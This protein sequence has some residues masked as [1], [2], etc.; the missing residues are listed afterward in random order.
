MANDLKLEYLR[1]AYDLAFAALAREVRNWIAFPAGEAGNG[2]AEQRVR[3]AEDL[4]RERRDALAAYLVR[5]EVERRAYRLWEQSGRP[6]GTADRD[7]T[8]AETQI[9]GS[10]RILSC[11]A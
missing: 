1:H 7:W 5:R 10:R 9:P 6:F 4:Y 11:V 3:I 8:R 2:V